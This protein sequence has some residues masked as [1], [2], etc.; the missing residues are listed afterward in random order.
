[1]FRSRSATVRIKGSGQ[2]L[3]LNVAPAPDPL[4]TIRECCRAAIAIDKAMAEAIREALA[5]GR[6]W[7]DVADAIGAAPAGTS[8]EALSHY[9]DGRG[10]LFRRLW[11]V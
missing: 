10:Q 6:S 11:G 1:M 9:L 3:R 2:R 8:E 5:S 7:A 4:G